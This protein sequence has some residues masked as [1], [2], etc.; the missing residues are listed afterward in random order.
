MRVLCMRRNT[1]PPK[2]ISRYKST[3]SM[4]LVCRRRAAQSVEFT[5]CRQ[6]DLLTFVQAACQATLCAIRAQ[7][8]RPDCHHCDCWE[9]SGGK[10]NPQGSVPGWELH[11]AAPQDPMC[12]PV[13]WL[14]V[15]GGRGPGW[16]GHIVAKQRLWQRPRAT[17][18]GSNNPP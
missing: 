14:T 2:S 11:N 9:G 7:D 6:P 8:Q 5:E 16:R 10:Q 13:S 4:L 15:G 1:V 3:N 17:G 12:F 18:T